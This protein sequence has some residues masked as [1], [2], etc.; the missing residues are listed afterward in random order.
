MSSN[1]HSPLCAILALLAAF[2]AHGAFP[3][4][5]SAMR[6]LLTNDDGYSSPGI[7]AMRSAL[8]AAGHDVVLVAPL[9]NQSGRGGAL[10]TR[11]GATV[12]I[13]EQAPDV[14]SVDG[15]PSDAVRAGLHAI[16]A[17]DPPDLVVSGSNFGQ[18]LGQ[19]SS[20]Y[21]GTIQAA[22]VGVFA[23]IPA[24]A[25]SVGVLPEEARATPIPFPSTIAAFAPTAAM[26]VRLIARLESTQGSGSFLPAR[27][28]LNI[29]VPPPYGSLRGTRFTRLGAAADFEFVWEDRF[30][31]VAA[32]GGRLL[33]NI[34]FPATAD[35]VSNSDR[36]AYGQHYVS[37]SLFDGNVDVDSVRSLPVR[38]RLASF[39]P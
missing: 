34:A 18:N 4:Q 8:V 5:A 3:S 35:A 39:T 15:T 17:A 33:I 29:N 11:V 19:P 13:R 36:E 16:M 25:V 21:S 20:L 12:E 14:W 10:D 22:L 28:M 9:V 6:I 23:D 30:G 38:T 7:Q 26:T 27:T 2:T 31:A 1:R 32:G 24:I 37:I